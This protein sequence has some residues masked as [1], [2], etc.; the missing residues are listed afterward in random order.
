METSK[1]LQRYEKSED[2]TKSS[3]YKQ[4]KKSNDGTKNSWYEMSTNGTKCLRY[5]KSMERKVRHSS[6]LCFYVLLSCFRLRD[7]IV[8]L[9]L[10]CQNINPWKWNYLTCVMTV[11]IVTYG[12]ID[13]RTD[14]NNLYYF[15]LNLINSCS[16]CYVV[17]RCIDLGC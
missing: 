16:S 6:Q 5:E 9:S 2:G 1:F 14:K 15:W 3:W 11:T 12:Q 17:C 13:R 10:I 8:S 7:Y 4:Y